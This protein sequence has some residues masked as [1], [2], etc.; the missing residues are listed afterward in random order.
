[1]E[2]VQI[3]VVQGYIQALE[4]TVLHWSR[5]IQDALSPETAYTTESASETQ[6][7]HGPQYVGLFSLHNL[8]IRLWEI[9]IL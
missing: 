6:A 9:R 2:D 3:P 4:G 5:Q 7:I 8:S 1:M